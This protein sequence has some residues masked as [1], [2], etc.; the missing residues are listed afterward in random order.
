MD[1]AIGII[2]TDRTVT[3]NIMMATMTSIIVMVTKITM[4]I[5]MV[6]AKI[7]ES[8]TTKTTTMNITTIMR[9]EAV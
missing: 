1:I 5:E 9:M 7:N 2:D 3:I 4:D 6:D 8:F